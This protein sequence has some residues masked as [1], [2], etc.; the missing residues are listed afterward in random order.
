LGSAAVA[1]SPDGRNVYLANSYS[2]VLNAFARAPDGSLT[3][4][5]NPTQCNADTSFCS[6]VAVTVSADGQ[7]VYIASFAYMLELPAGAV[8]AFARDADGALTQLPG[9]TGCLSVSAHPPCAPARAMFGAA[10]V[11]ISP[12]DMS[13]YVSADGDGLA[14][15]DRAPDGSLTQEPSTAS[16]FSVADDP[17]CQPA[18]G[19]R[20]ASETA[21]SPDGASVYLAASGDDAVAIFDRTLAPPVPAPPDVPAPVQPAPDHPAAQPPAVDRTRPVL[22]RLALSPSRFRVARSARRDG[23]RLSFSLSEPAAV[24]LTFQRVASGRRSGTRCLAARRRTR[25]A[26][27]CTRYVAVRGTLTYHAKVGRNIVRL[28]GRV[29]KRTLTPHR[30]RLSAV[31]TDA[32]A[33]SSLRRQ[34]YFSIVA[35]PRR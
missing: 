29:G 34:I 5:A 11:T 32:A 23:S 16:C 33:H 10:G 25:R 8:V 9:P 35:T 14:L 31:A 28:T 22:G 21:V 3:Q 12:D 17:F 4:L 20:Y 27:R 24:K 30:Y 18:R 2:N 15:F 6:P 13:V 19:T 26:V 1:V 7:N